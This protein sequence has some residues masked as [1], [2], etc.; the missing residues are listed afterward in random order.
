[1]K[2]EYKKWFSPS[3]G[4]DM[5]MLT[6]GHAGLPTLVFPTSCGRFF[7]F[8]DRGMVASVHDKLEHGHVQ[9][10]CVDSVDQESW[11][12]RSVPPRWRIARHMQY[13]QYLMQEVLPLMRYDNR[14]CHL[15][16]TGCSFGGFHAFNIAL[17]HP[18]VFSAVLS[19]SGCFDTAGFLSGYYDDDCYFNI[20]P[21]YL[22]NIGDPWYLDHYRRNTYVLATGTHDQCWNDNE[23]MAQIF[24]AKD[25]PCRLDV[26]GDDTGH[27]WPYWQ[28]MLQTYI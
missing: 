14:P 28:R 25:I 17:R 6:F 3:L 8:E 19:M 13:E 22:A 15:A 7:E 2:R 5:E 18:D 1:M 10:F 21:H 16:A 12:N 9:L 23:R 24:R 4:R 11:Y 27:D 26:W 20:P